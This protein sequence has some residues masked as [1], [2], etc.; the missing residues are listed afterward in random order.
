MTEAD[1]NRLITDF[2]A[3]LDTFESTV[4]AVEAAQQDLKHAKHAR[5]KERSR[6]INEFS[7]AIRTA[8]EGE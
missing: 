1:F 4:I 5:T 7:G 2:M 6:L 3:E 8:L